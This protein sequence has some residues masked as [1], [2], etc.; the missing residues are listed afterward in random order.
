[1][2]RLSLCV[3]LLLTV[4]CATHPAPTPVRLVPPP[5]PHELYTETMFDMLLYRLELL[6]RHVL[7]TRQAILEQ[8]TRE[9]AR[10]DGK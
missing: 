4:G 3:F 9:A 6:E 10:E 5:I 1:M 7:E 8:L 2:R